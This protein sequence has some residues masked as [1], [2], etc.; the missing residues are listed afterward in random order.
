MANLSVT[1]SNLFAG[2]E[3]GAAPD[4]LWLLQLQRPLAT[5][6]DAALYSGLRAR[7]GGQERQ[8]ARN[9]RWVCEY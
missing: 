2:G 6:Q 9:C 7:R 4:L 1:G 8:A 3:V 5:D